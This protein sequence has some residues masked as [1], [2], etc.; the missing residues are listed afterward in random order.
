MAEDKKDNFKDAASQLPGQDPAEKRGRGRPPGAKNK[1]PR[2]PGK[3]E[4]IDTPPVLS[5]PPADVVE[6]VAK[7]TQAVCN[8]LLAVDKYP[9]LAVTD[10]EARNF[11][12]PT[13]QLIDYYFKLN[14]PIVFVWINLGIQASILFTARV[15]LIKQIK[16][17]QKDKEPKEEVKLKCEKCPNVEFTDKAAFDKHIKEGIHEQ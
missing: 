6:S 12:Y 9:Q 13:A 5:A 8:M 15:K 16:Q 2:E 3:P 1:E 17:E 10:N 7:A 4:H 14:N 11:A